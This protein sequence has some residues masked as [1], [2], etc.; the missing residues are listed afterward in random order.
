[1]KAWQSE[2]PEEKITVQEWAQEKGINY[3]RL[4]RRW[5]GICSLYDRLASHSRLTP[6]QSQSLIQYIKARDR[7]CLPLPLKLVKHVADSIIYRGL[8]EEER[9]SFQPVST[10]WTERWLVKHR[11]GLIKAKPI[12]LARKEAHQ[13]EE[14]RRWFDS[15]TATCEQYNI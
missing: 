3:Q 4:N 14:I 15:Y 6:L 8:L 2:H 5:K 13:P 10:S 1:M 7:M 11:I 9:Y 12:E